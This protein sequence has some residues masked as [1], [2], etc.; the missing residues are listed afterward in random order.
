MRFMPFFLLSLIAPSFADTPNWL[1]IGE[2]GA[3]V[4]KKSDILSSN[5]FLNYDKLIITNEGLQF[6]GKDTIMLDKCN[7]DNNVRPIWCERSDGLWS[8]NFMMDADNVFV[9]SILTLPDKGEQRHSWLIG[10]C[11]KI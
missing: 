1:C 7:R 9:L 10:R 2:H 11:S 3:Q 5:S 8:G 6:F 4:K